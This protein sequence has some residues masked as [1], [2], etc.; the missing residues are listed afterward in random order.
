[1]MYNKRVLKILKGSKTKMRVREKNVSAANV[2]KHCEEAM[3]LYCEGG[4]NF[5]LLPLQT[6]EYIAR[7]QM[8]RI[9]FLKKSSSAVPAE[10]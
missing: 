6:Q 9:L 3:I 7:S 2:R 10:G 5:K 8:S 1:M 4:K